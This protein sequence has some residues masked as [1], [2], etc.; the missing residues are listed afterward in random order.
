[1]SP[2]QMTSLIGY[3]VGHEH[4]VSLQPN[5]LLSV[6]RLKGISH[7]TT[8]SAT[9]EQQFERLN[10]Y[11]LALGKK[12][13]ANLML[14]TYTTKAGLELDTRY[15]LPLRPLQDFVDAYTQPFRDGTYRQVGY[16]L[17]LIL[18]YR[19][20]DDG[21]K[22]MKDLLMVSKTMLADYDP[23]F[24]G[25]EENAHGALISQV[26]R[27]FSQ[28]FNGHEQDV[29]VGNTR[30]GD[31]VI[32]SVTSFGAL[33]YVQNRPNRGGTRYATTYDLRSLPNAGTFS[34][35]W[36]EA[37][38]QQIDFTLVQTFLFEDRNKAKRGFNKQLFD[39]AQT[40]GETKQTDELNT[41]VGDIT[42]G[43]LSFGRYHAALIVY[44][45]TPDDAIENGAKMESIFSTYDT[46]FVRS[47]I[48]NV[49]TWFAQFPAYLDVPY[50]QTKS[51]ENLACT[52]S[53]HA[54]PVGKAK[55]NPI[56]NGTALM[57]AR[58]A[59]DGMFFLNAH[60]SPTGQNNVGEK[61]PG[62][63]CFTGMTG[64]GKTTVEAMTLV[65]F[66][67]FNP[68]LFAIDYNRSL[69]NLLRAFKTKYFA[70][71]PMQFT[72]VNPFQLQD[73]PQLR[74]FLYETVVA[75]A[76]G[77]D[78]CTQ[79]EERTIQ[80]SIAAVLEHS[81]VANRGMSL[82]LQNIP[83]LG[84]NCLRT[85]LA[86]W[87]R[88][89][90]GAY[91]WV[92]DSPSNQ[93]DPQVYRRL[94]FDCTN[95]LKKEFVGKHP[96]AIQVLLNTL[97]FLKRLMHQNEPGA[98]LLNVVAEYWVPLMFESTAE[99][100]KEVLKA[101]RT[102]GEIL[103]MDT[104]SPEDS[105]DSP[106]GPA[107][108]Q[109]TVTTCW[110]ANTKADPAAYAKFGIKGKVFDVIKAQHPQ[111]R[112]MVVVQGHQAIQL[113]MDLPEELKYWLPL[114]STTAENAAI[115]QEIRTALDTEDPEV[116]VPELLEACKKSE[117]PKLKTLAEQ[118]QVEL[119]SSVPAVWVPTFVA[120]RAGRVAE[121]A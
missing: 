85:R 9:L 106:Y 66:S 42:L 116:W 24:M 54:T 118:V 23:A 20:L 82:L 41:A 70:I 63:M 100:I 8:D 83:F 67:R 87:S 110:L 6:I 88:T 18:R 72:G 95:V 91:A 21:L 22:R 38:G 93:F 101:G 71:E 86:K 47:T 35:M 58:T 25:I 26:G 3:H 68:M 115:A 40:E 59:S 15:E 57:P 2:E 4:I 50:P 53:L 120:A 121:P 98:L 34:G 11:F 52:F 7:E 117:D 1:M 16:T 46:S 99:A 10:R 103:I 29:L 119:R 5:R 111:D 37:V 77:G 33:D 90:G 62:H 64:A 48:T 78:Q 112:G 17:V 84:G 56:G 105:A 30:L 96:I 43:E 60:D 89:E 73:T 28:V 13:G 79:E 19:D 12:E 45:E 69:E 81:N 108:I 102:R 109:Q 39:L 55:G 27:F 76:G 14:Q 36:D 75:C 44:G 107:V 74:Q 114:L 49:Y 113:K 32:D 31:A 65:F 92:L 94:A 97:F 80:Q 51:T 104:Q 61:L